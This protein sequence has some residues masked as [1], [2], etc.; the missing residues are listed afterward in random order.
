[1]ENDLKNLS[2]ALQGERKK[3]M[4]DEATLKKLEFE[5]RKKTEQANKN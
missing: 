1:L 2:N 5:L 4:A 3:S